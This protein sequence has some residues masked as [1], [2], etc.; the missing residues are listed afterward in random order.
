VK[1]KSEYITT[2]DPDEETKED[3]LSQHQNK[4]CITDEESRMPRRREQNGARAVLSD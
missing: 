2:Q 4:I 3:G 1:R